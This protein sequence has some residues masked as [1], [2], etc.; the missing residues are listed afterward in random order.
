[1]AAT[2]SDHEPKKHKNAINKGLK[3]RKKEKIIAEFALVLAF[4]QISS[5]KHECDHSIISLLQIV[6]IRRLEIKTS[7][8]RF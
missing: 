1:M 4:L 5:K 6:N 7:L 3:G 2:R 8:V